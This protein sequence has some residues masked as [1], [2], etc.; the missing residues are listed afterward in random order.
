[1]C[2]KCRGKVTYSS[3]FSIDGLVVPAVESA[4][5]LGD[6]VSRDLSP[7]LLHISNIVAKAHERTAATYRAF[8]F[9][10]ADLLIRAD[11]TNVRP[12]VEHD[13]VTWSPW[14]C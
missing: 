7:S 5:D 9:R 3:C 14:S 4:R 13:S 11:L 12:L 2:A 1:L 8:R 6:I 10:N